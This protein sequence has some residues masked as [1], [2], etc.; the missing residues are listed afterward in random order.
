M[1]LT[2]SGHSFEVLSLEGVLSLCKHL[3]F[4]GVDISGFHARGRCSIEPEDIAADPQGE[5][6]K[7]KALL[8]KYELDAVDFFP[9]FGTSPADHGLN[10]PNPDIRERNAYLIGRIAEFCNM[11]G[12]PGMTILPGVEH[13]GRSQQE[14]LEVSGQEMKR[15]TEIAGEHGIK[16]RYEAHMGSITYTPELAIQ[17]IEEYAPDAKLT[18][19]YTHFVLQYIPVE[20]IHALLPYTDHVHVRASRPGKMQTSYTDGTIDYPDIIRRLKAI[21]YQSTVSVEYV[22]QDWF[23]CNDVDTLTETVIT[24]EA[25]EP[26]VGKL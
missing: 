14:N 7:L 20:R 11:V 22:Y 23:G 10:D 9:Q 6:D 17:L 24:K 8:D 25:L 19:D 5:A 3:G 15:A 18:L 12:I 4:K 2:I 26:L 1:R 13:L 16:L 21:D